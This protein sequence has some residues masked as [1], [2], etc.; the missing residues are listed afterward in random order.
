M[1]GRN[2]WLTREGGL[3]LWLSG[4]ASG[5]RVGADARRGVEGLPVP[6]E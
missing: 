4:S 1:L 3:S 5:G 2:V 6:A